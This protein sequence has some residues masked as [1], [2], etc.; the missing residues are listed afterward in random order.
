MKI[1]TERQKEA[2]RLTDIYQCSQEE[3]GE[4]MGISQ[5]AVS[6]LLQRL[7]KKLKKLLKGKSSHIKRKKAFSFIESA[8]STP[9]QRF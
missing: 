8:G 6:R 5:Q 4:L 2:F 3:A 7:P 9:K 1:P